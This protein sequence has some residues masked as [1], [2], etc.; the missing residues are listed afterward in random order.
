MQNVGCVF[1]S[2]Q[3]Q[4]SKYD[5]Q[6]FDQS[7]GEAMTKGTQIVSSAGK[8]LEPVSFQEINGLAIIP[9]PNSATFVFTTT[10]PCQPIISIFPVASASISNDTQPKKVI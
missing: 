2:G 4:R 8:R 6:T 5:F 3:P 9:N 7:I 10:R 1:H